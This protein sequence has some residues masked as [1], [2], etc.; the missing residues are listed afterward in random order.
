MTTSTNIKKRAEA[1]RP[2]LP[3]A[4][5]V[6]AILA[7]YRGAGTIYSPAQISKWLE[8]PHEQ[9]LASM[10]VLAT[11]PIDALEGRWVLFDVDDEQYDL[12]P[13]DVLTA[14]EEGVLY[15]PETGFPIP[16]F[17]RRVALIYRARPQLDDLARDH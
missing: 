8:I 16:N 9:V 5:I 12:T 1:L 3:M 11:D 15:H 14:D 4:Q 6:D 10:L 17:R 2:D 7:H 13:D